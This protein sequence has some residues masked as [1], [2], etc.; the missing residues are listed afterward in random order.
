MDT[1]ENYRKIIKSILEPYTKIPYA[2]G[3]L[4]MK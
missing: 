4:S 1:L 2:H 3:E